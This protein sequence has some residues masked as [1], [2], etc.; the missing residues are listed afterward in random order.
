[1]PFRKFTAFAIVTSV[2]LTGCSVV[3]RWVYRPDINQGNYV[4][5]DAIDLLQVG[6]NKK[7]VVF[8][9]GAPML[10]SVFGGNVWYYVFRQQPQHGAVSQRMYAVYFDE[11]GIVKDIKASALAESK[12][13][14]EMNKQDISDPIDTKSD[15]DNTES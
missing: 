15:D 5:Q 14:D 1:M 6:Q 11:K 13:L 3:D 12:S 8:I 4:T 9:M 2:L 7:Q 10:T